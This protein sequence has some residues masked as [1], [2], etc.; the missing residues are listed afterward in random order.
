MTKNKDFD[1]GMDDAELEEGIRQAS[2]FEQSKQLAEDIRQSLNTL[3]SIDLSLKLLGRSL[4][5]LQQDADCLNADL[6]DKV[7]QLQNAL[8]IVIP[9]ETTEHLNYVFSSFCKTFDKT[10]QDKLDA[11]IQKAEQDFNAAEK[12]MKEQANSMAKDSKRIVLPPTL[13]SVCLTLLI[14]FIV[15]FSIVWC[16]NFYVIHSSEIQNMCHLL[17]VFVVVINAFIISFY[18]WFY[19]K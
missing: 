6:N 11:A 5:E 13:C 9:S 2:E 3:K 12:R 18:H 17:I 10:L 14:C 15:F 7:R 8:T 1:F 16:F 19:N 4:V